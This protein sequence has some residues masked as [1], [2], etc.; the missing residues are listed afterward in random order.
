[1]AHT[2]WRLNVSVSENFVIFAELKFYDGTGTQIATSGG[3]PSSST[4]SGAS[5]NAFDGNVSTDWSAGAPSPQW[6]QYQFA[7]AVDVVSFSVTSSATQPGKGPMDCQLQYSDDGTTWTTLYSYFGVGWSASQITQTFNA[8]NAA[9]TLGIAWRVLI[10]VGT[11][12]QGIYELVFYDRTGAAI[13]T[14]VFDAVANSW[15]SGGT[16]AYLA[17]DGNTVSY[18][19]ANGSV[20][21]WLEYR[22][23][24]IA[25]VVGSISVRG[26]GGGG[27]TPSE[28]SLQYS[29]DDVNWFTA[30]GPWTAANWGTFPVQTFPPSGTI[31]IPATQP[32]HF[33][34]T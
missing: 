21:S 1:M 3:T 16:A 30:G 24:N 6:L 20:P 33:V 13:S 14:T 27:G 4:N 10:T 15:F 5:G 11:N 9:P 7:S 28:L 2:Y 19:N 32:Q 12:N 22:F 29:Y 31:Y 17:F 8:A 23:G 25:I 26:G 34:V 18:W